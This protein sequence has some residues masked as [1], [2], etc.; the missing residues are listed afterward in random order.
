WQ[1]L[2]TGLE[3]ASCAAGVEIH[4][5]VRIAAVTRADGGW[6]L[7]TAGGKHWT[8]GAVLLT[9]SPA[10]VASLVRDEDGQYLQRWAEAAL[11]VRAACLTVG[12]ARLPRPDAC[13]EVAVNQPL[14]F[15]AHSVFARLA[16]AAGATI[17]LVKYLSTRSQ[18]DARSDECEL[19]DFLDLMQPGWRPELRQRSF[20]PR[21]AVANAL[22]T[23][24]AGGTSGR[25]SPA[26]PGMPGLYVAGD[27]VGN[28]GLLADASLASARVAAKVIAAAA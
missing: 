16:P 19:E 8:S 1:T 3:A 21:M 5:G 28:E 18:T 6:T 2:V 23:A 13:W 15:A 24:E 11:P 22:P 17:H 10:V 12:L 25:P 7:R 9:G 14:Y 26:V 20:L 27:W 4:T